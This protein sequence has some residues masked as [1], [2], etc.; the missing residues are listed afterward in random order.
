MLQTNK[1]TYKR[2]SFYSVMIRQF[3]HAE[4]YMYLRDSWLKQ[5]EYAYS[6]IGVHDRKALAYFVDTD[7]DRWQAI[8]DNIDDIDHVSE[9]IEFM[10]EALDTKSG[11]C[12]PPYRKIENA[13]QVAKLAARHRQNADA[14][15]HIQKLEHEK[16]GLSANMAAMERDI[17]RLNLNIELL[18]KNRAQL[19]QSRLQ[20]LSAMQR[21]I[22]DMH[23]AQQKTQAELDLNT[24][25]LNIW[26]R[27]RATLH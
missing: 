15:T 18:R 6:L 11:C 22:I 19:S 7:Y 2:N 5:F 16:K 17:R 10:D 9:A 8:C 14:F 24:S 23:K 3:V 20:D 4:F 27:Y 26:K 13:I 12:R 21:H 1:S 25:A